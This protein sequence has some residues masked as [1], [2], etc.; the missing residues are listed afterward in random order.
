MITEWLNFQSDEG[1]G[2]TSNGD[3]EILLEAA[4]SPIVESAP[5]DAVQA[6]AKKTD[7]KTSSKSKLTEWMESKIKHQTV[8]LKYCLSHQL[9]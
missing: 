1:A 5:V 2:A 8:N 7:K 3:V 4:E 6:T 9:T